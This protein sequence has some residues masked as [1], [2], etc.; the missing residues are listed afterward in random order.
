MAAWSIVEAELGPLSQS[1]FHC[2]AFPGIFI[3]NRLLLHGGCSG[4]N[5]TCGSSQPGAVCESQW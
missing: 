1:P 4:V 3:A 2:K 5:F